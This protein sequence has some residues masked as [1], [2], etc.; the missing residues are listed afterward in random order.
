MDI[1]AFAATDIQQRKANKL[2]HNGSP[3]GAC[4][5]QVE[6][7]DQKGIQG[8]I[9]HRTGADAD[10]GIDGAALKTELVI[11]NQRSGHP[12]CA[13]QNHPQIGFGVGENGLGGTQQICQIFQKNLAHNTDQKTGAQSAEKAGGGHG[14]SLII[15]L[16]TQCPGDVVAAALAEEESHG[17]DDGHHGEYHTYRTGSGVAFQ[18]TYEERIG[19]IVKRSDQHTDDAGN[20]QAAD[21]FA[22]GL[23][24]HLYELFFLGYHGS[25][26][27]FSF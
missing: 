14:G 15:L 6:Y 23:L 8:D 16:F 13:Q 21:G 20:S 3:A 19:H 26:S 11:Q 1:A 27:L 25:P 12:R 9:Q 22:N 4:H 5:T 18:H 17:L 24:G 10:H 2:A 7:E